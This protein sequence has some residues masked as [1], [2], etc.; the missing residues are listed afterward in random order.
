MYDL[1]DIT[2]SAMQHSALPLQWV[3]MEQIAV[4]LHLAVDNNPPQTVAAK[5]NV[6]VSLD[7]RNAKGIHMSRLHR[8]LNQLAEA[9]S[10][11]TTLDRLLDELISSQGGLSQN[12][13][14]ELSFELLLK[15]SALLSGESGYQTYPMVIRGEVAGGIRSYA[16]EVTIPY[17]STCPCS[18]SL[19]RQL[20]AE[21]IA[22]QFAGD[23]I[24]KASLLN[25]VASAEGS[26]ATPHSQRSYAYLTLTTA[27]NAWPDFATL[28]AHL[29]SA[30]GTPVQTAVKRVD[31]QEF[32]RLNAE[33]LLFCEDAARR[34]KQTLE[35]MPAIIDYWF[36]VEHQESLHAHNA[37]VIDRK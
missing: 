19:S 12:G 2:S 13:R 24:D 5:A 4:P 18:A 17:S 26:I 22:E 16:L 29:E 1:P 33:N 30:I 14:L 8:L 15:R 35:H 20:Y 32:A 28:I 36:K 3:G 23:T 27:D 37:V 34:I 9:E 21:A 10:S 11:K 7:D 31:E 25:W 6:F